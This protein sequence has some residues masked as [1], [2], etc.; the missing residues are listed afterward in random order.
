MHFITNNL[1]WIFNGKRLNVCCSV[2]MIMILSDQYIGWNNMNEIND[3]DILI[4][5]EPK[6]DMYDLKM[7]IDNLS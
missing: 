2:K 6:E 5:G 1:E 3:F 4:C 7:I